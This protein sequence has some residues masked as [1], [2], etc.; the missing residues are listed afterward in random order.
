MLKLAISLL[1]LQWFSSVKTD[2]LSL[3]SCI[4]KLVCHK[5]KSLRHGDLKRSL[6]WL[7]LLY[8]LMRNDNCC[9]TECVLCRVDCLH[10]GTAV[11]HQTDTECRAP[12]GAFSFLNLQFDLPITV[13]WVVL[14]GIVLCVLLTLSIVTVALWKRADHFHPVVCSLSFFLA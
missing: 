4:I 12:T 7:M 2:T 6:P 14:L 1:M 8:L 3:W 11:T 9:Y 13:Q 5:M 10:H